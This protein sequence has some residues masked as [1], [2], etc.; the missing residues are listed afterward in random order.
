M[1]DKDI[2]QYYYNVYKN[3][4]LNAG[5]MSCFVKSLPFVSAV[6]LSDLN[7][8]TKVE[9]DISKIKALKTEDNLII[10]DIPAEL[11]MEY[12]YNYRD[13][14]TIIPDFNMV[15]HDFGIVKSKPLLERLTLFSDI[16]LKNTDRYMIILDSNRYRDIEINNMN[17]YNNQYEV[18][19][20]EL[21]ELE[22]LEFLKI[23]TVSYIGSDNVKEDIAEYL[24][25]LKAN[26]IT[27]NIEYV[28]LNKACENK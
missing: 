15:C 7:I 25:Y 23:N 6:N 17:E 13:K 26:K 9:L 22:I 21:P 11:G 18:T 12:A 27:V 10:L 5:I 2:K 4:Y 24:N 8:G 14:Y 16:K 19:E 20:E 28:N 3:F 1:I